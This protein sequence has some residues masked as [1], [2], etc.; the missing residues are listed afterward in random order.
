MFAVFAPSS[1]STSSNW[2]ARA[3]GSACV[4]EVKTS[5]SGLSLSSSNEIDQSEM[6]DAKGW[7][8]LRKL[9]PAIKMSPYKNSFDSLTSFLFPQFQFSHSLQ[10]IKSLFIFSVLASFFLNFD[11]T[12]RS[13][14]KSLLYISAL[15]L[16]SFCSKFL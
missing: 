9:W 8:R 3:S 2:F 6:P 5:G 16:R 12:P 7:S 14:I 4:V 13:K 1:S 10:K 11:F 15:P